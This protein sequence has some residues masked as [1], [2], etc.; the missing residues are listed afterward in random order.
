MLILIILC[1]N[2]NSSTYAQQMQLRSIAWSDILVATLLHAHSGIPRF[3]IRSFD[4]LRIDLSFNI[5]TCL[6]FQT[7]KSSQDDRTIQLS[8]S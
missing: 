4:P 3:E 8:G 6:P 1:I 5:Y 2:M 7:S